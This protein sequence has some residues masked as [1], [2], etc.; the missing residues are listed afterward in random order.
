MKIMIAVLFTVTFALAYCII[1]FLIFEGIDHSEK[2]G[3]NI[4]GVV[5]FRALHFSSYRLFP[6]EKPS[7]TRNL[8]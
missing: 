4:V 5:I 7:K 8:L 2:H 1:W 6:F 3:R